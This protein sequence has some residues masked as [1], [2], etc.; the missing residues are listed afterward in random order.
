MNRLEEKKRKHSGEN[1]KS[2]SENGKL[3]RRGFSYLERNRKGRDNRKISYKMFLKRQR[4]Q[5]S[6]KRKRIT[7]MLKLLLRNKKISSKAIA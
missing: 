5:N 4:N 6:R 3:K 7:M 2:W 1:K